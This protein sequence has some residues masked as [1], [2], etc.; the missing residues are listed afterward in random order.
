MSLKIIRNDI[1]KMNTEAIVN[2]AN[3][4]PTVGS[5]CDTAVYNAAGFDEL[6]NYRKEKIGF[7]KEG[8]VFITPGFNLSAKYIIHSVSPRFTTEDETEKLVREC[9]RKSLE[10]AKKNN[11]KSI[12]FP[13]IA[14]GSYGFPKEAG[15]RVALDEINKFLLKDDME[16]YIVAF[17]PE[18]T[19]LSAKISARLEEYI[20]E[21]YVDEKIDEEYSRGLRS[22]V[23]YVESSRCMLDEEA[24]EDHIRDRRFFGDLG[25]SSRIDSVRP[26]SGI[27]KHSKKEFNP[28]KIGRKAKESAPVVAEEAEPLIDE[29]GL[30]PAAT[31]ALQERLAHLSDTFS[32]YLMFLIEEKGL[33]APEVYNGACVDK[34]VFSKIKKNI[35]YHPDKKT[36][37]CL[38]IG[39]KLNIDQTKDLLGKA[40]YALSNSDM[41]DVIFQFFIE[42]EI[43]SI[44]DLDIIL[45][46][47]GLPCF[48][49]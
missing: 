47:H 9:Y 19:T 8:D 16:V 36:A 23:L 15:L 38:C 42:N 25:S 14:T 32:Q 37:L 13:L 5:G 30:T 49:A 28:I 4:K 39:A 45:E 18:S 12:A 1:T 31:K 27:E 3:E 26:K 7:V 20:D 46:E 6:L 29:Y 33:K 34:R 17:D 2:T 48:I 41:T 40:G 22:N 11:I 21:N 10:L 44:V 35:N 43:Y 24:A